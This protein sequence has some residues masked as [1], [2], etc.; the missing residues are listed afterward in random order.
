MALSHLIS[1][2]SLGAQSKR[3]RFVV[4]ILNVCD[5]RDESLS[6]DADNG[7][8][9]EAEE[10]G[11]LGIWRLGGRSYSNASRIWEN[12]NSRCGFVSYAISSMT[13]IFQIK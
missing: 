11:A 8:R 12:L 6:S 10:G 9:G 2:S 3:A 7:G 4:T 5:F 1:S 13:C